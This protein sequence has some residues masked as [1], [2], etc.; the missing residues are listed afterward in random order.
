M[1]KR[2]VDGIC[3]P[4]GEPIGLTISLL[5]RED[6]WKVHLTACEAAS[7]SIL[8]TDLPSTRGLNHRINMPRRAVADVVVVLR[9]NPHPTIFPQG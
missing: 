4:R 9:N 7:L 1:I 3:E 2:G 8:R 6:P 5:H